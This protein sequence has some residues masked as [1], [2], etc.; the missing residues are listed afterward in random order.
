[1]SPNDLNEMHREIRAGQRGCV[2]KAI[3]LGR[4]LAHVREDLPHGSWL[5]WVRKN[6]AFG[7]ETARNYLAMAEHSEL[8]A[9]CTSIRQFLRRIRFRKSVE[10]RRE[11]AERGR[12]LHTPNWCNLY[13]ADFRR[14]P[15]LLPPGT[16]SLCVADPVWADDLVHHY[17]D[18]DEVASEVLKQGGVLLVYY[19]R[20]H[21]P[22]VL[23]AFRRL[24]FLD[25]VFVVY[26]APKQLWTSGGMVCRTRPLLL[27][28]KGDEPAKSTYQ[29]HDTRLGTVAPPKDYH[30]W[31]QDEPALR[32]WVERFT[33]PGDTVVDLFVGG[34]TLAASCHHLKGRTYHG[35]D[36]DPEA[37]ATTRK[38][39][40]DLEQGERVADSSG[41]GSRHSVVV[42]RANR[43]SE[44]V[45]VSG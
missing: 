31:E 24:R 9:R 30:K 14:M 20:H 34:G 44:H 23:S 39:L 33:E 41:G 38:R 4:A 40:S 28:V 45:N 37:L 22:E 6:L 26:T 11:A 19:S 36:T 32:Y 2:E 42:R 3:D 13:E 16:A 35:T 17:E 8:A 43:E 7:D 29:M 25:Q 5:P 18:I 15:D 1:M 10:K 12:A 21:L 27:F